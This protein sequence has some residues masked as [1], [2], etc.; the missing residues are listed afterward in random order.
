M[1]Y[2]ERHLSQYIKLLSDPI[3]IMVICIMI[4]SIVC[5]FTKSWN[6]FNIMAITGTISAIL[7]KQLYQKLR[8]ESLQ[9]RRQYRKLGKS[10]KISKSE[11][12]QYLFKLIPEKTS[13]YVTGNA[14]NIPFLKI[15][16]NFYKSSFFPSSII[17]WNKL[18]PNLHN[19]ENFGIF[20][21]N[22]QK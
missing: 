20:K 15:K 4:K 8:L 22:I 6:P 19:S 1:F 9:L 10:Y 16:Q 17:E 13:S 7:E 5:L 11:S 12:P 14:D 21:N 2:Q 3:L 18:D